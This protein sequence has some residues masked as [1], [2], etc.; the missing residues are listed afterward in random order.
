M[1]AKVRLKKVS[2]SIG[3]NLI[4]IIILIFILFP[5]IWVAITSLKS[6]DE[7]FAIPIKY[8]PK[9]PTLI[10]YK[11][12]FFP[13]YWSGQ[14]L[15]WHQYLL[16]SLF[17]AGISTFFVLFFGSM[18][19]YAFSRFQFRGSKVLLAILVLTRMLPGP[20]L[21]VPIYVMISKY[22]IRDTLWGLILVHSAFGL[23]LTTW[24]CAGF[25]RSVP[26]DL[27]EAAIVD[28]CTR[29]KA[30]LRVV[31]PIAFIG[32]ISV[33]AYHFVGSWSEFAFASRTAPVGLGDFIFL[34]GASYFNRVGAAA[35]TMAIPITAIFLFAQRHFVR[36][37][38]AGAVK[39]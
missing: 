4:G 1:P 21:M 14:A 39:E 29:I 35:V 32:I 9:K 18:A 6:H 30:L 11:E 5:V 19:G 26:K 38:L 22:G 37:F 20:A 13:G 8:F 17:V 7:L 23:P 15:L 27:E 3:L 36:G 28:G 2:K 24:L 25:F 16:N 10:S 34:F 31:I 12:I 33:G